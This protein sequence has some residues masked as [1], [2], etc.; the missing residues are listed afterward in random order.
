M[1]GC[2]TLLVGVSKRHLVSGGTSLSIGVSKRYLVAR[3]CHKLSVRG[4]WW[5]V[6]Q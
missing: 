6:N 5:Y 3:H 1:S 2:T 4:I